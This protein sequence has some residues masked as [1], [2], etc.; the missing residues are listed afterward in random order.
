MLQGNF[1]IGNSVVTGIFL[2]I[3][4]SQL[5]QIYTNIYVF[6]FFVFVWGG[7]VAVTG[8]IYSKS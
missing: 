2:G 8:I 3:C 6:S 7:G 5:K 4:Q 1:D